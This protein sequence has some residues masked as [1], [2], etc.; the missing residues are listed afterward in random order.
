MQME[1]IRSFEQLEQYSERLKASYNP[2]LPTVMICFG[3]GC[4]AN[5]SREVADAFAEEIKQRGL[6][7]NVE[8]GIKTTG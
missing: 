8:I 5:G 1:S 7:V 6:K 2:D 3:T 4:L